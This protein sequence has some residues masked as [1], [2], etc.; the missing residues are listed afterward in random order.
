MDNQSRSLKP[1]LNKTVFVACSASKK[2]ELV[3]GL[4]L[5]GAT[6]I[7]I[8]VIE[9]VELDDKRLLDEAL[10]SLEQYSWIIFTSTYG[11]N[12]FSQRLKT[13]DIKMPPQE[14]TKICAIGP[15]TAGTVC[16]FGYDVELIPEQFVAEGVIA[17]LEKYLE[18][19]GGFSDQRILIP[20]AKEGRE[21]L[22]T[23]LKES[24]A[25][26]DV[27]PCY[28][29]IQPK[30]EQALKDQLMQKHLDLIIFTSSSTV[31]NLLGIFGEEHGLKLLR[32]S[33]VAVIGPI[34]A[35]TVDSF[36]GKVN[37]VPKESS[38]SSLLEAIREFYILQADHQID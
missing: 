9:V 30:I 3:S 14:Y 13:L 15:G 34:T 29:T 19:S 24:G 33:I 8:P 17:A 20:R 12:Y 1:L 10:R 36:G 26:V 21:L 28:Q 22:P 31:K 2:D 25:Q 37:I 6:A 38:L 27:V 18:G 23:A 5:L 11:V 35:G 32:E 4:E 7:H 16:E